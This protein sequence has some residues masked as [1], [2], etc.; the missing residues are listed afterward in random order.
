M[1]LM[2]GDIGNGSQKGDIV[3]D[4]NSSLLGDLKTFFTVSNSVMEALYVSI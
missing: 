3:G 1:E 2:G 4:R